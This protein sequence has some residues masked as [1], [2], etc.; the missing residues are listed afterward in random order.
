MGKLTKPGWEVSGQVSSGGYCGGA[1]PPEGTRAGVPGGENLSSQD[2]SV[3]AATIRFVC[4]NLTG[5]AWSPAG[6]APLPLTDHSQQQSGPK[7][8]PS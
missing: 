4:Q 3:S 2:A 1:E 7:A 5:Q 8:I 6:R